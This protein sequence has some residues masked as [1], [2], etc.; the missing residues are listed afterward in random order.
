MLFNTSDIREKDVINVCTG[1][2]IGYICDFVIDASCGRIV[3]VIVSCNYFSLMGNKNSV[4]IPWDKVSC[5]GDD[6]VLVLAD[7]ECI[8]SSDCETERC[9]RADKRRKGWFF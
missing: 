1:K 8:C 7:G 2:R 9:S 3:S 4:C 6:A 5:I